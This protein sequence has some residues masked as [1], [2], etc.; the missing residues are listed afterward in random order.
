VA[1]WI[2]DNIAVLEMAL[3][4]LVMFGFL[5]WQYWTVRNARDP[6]PGKSD[7]SAHPAGHTEGQHQPDERVL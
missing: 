4:A 3:S 7:D 2:G 6:A 5:G 1:Q